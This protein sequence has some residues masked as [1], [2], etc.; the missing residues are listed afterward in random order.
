MWGCEK[1]VLKNP[2]SLERIL[3]HFLMS[4]KFLSLKKYL[5]NDV[6]EQWGIIQSKF[7]AEFNKK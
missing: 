1:F 7:E 6:S 5:Q 2:K 4:T 3:S